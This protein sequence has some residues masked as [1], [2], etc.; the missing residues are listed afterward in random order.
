MTTEFFAYN[1]KHGIIKTHI[2]PNNQLGRRV[3]WYW[4]PRDPIDQKQKSSYFTDKWVNMEM[5]YVVRIS[6][7]C[8]GEL[9]CKWL[10]IGSNPRYSVTTN[11][12]QHYIRDLTTILDLDVARKLNG[13]MD[14]RV[15]AAAIPGKVLADDLNEE[16]RINDIYNELKQTLEQFKKQQLDDEKVDEQV[17]I[18]IF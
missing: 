1:D 5:V 18:F 12:C 3:F 16:A 9:I 11:N 4:W 17:F 10:S 8:I 15:V 14:H 6:I 7:Q 13:F 2:V